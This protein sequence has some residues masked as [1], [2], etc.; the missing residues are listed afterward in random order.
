[1]TPHMTILQRLCVAG[2][3][4]LPVTLAAQR[5]DWIYYTSTHG[6]NLRNFTQVDGEG[7][8]VTAV[9]YSSTITVGGTTFG[10][11]GL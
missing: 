8:T 4:L 11:D 1:M 6:S 2:L 3:A 9:E 5:T 7:A 10:S